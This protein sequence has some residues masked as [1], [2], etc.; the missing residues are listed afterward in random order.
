MK[1]ILCAIGLAALLLASSPARETLSVKVEPEQTKI[2]ASDGAEVII[3]I[4]LTA[5]P[6]PEK[7]LRQPLNLAVVLDRSGSMSG[8]KIEKAKQ[9]A[10]AVLDQ[11][12]SN[13]VY[14]LVAYDSQVQVLVPAQTI[15]D[16]EMLKARIFRIQPGGSTALYGG[17]ERGAEQLLKFLSSKRINR[18]IL[19]SDGLANVGPSSTEELQSLGRRLSQKGVAVTTV[20]V[21]DDYNEDLMAGLAESSDANYYYVKDAETLP[22]IFRKELGFLL[23]VTAQEVEVEINVAVGVEPLGFI[24]RSEH[25]EKRKAVVRFGP[26]SAEQN[27]YLFLRARLEDGKGKPNR[28]IAAVTV[29]YRDSSDQVQIIRHSAVVSLTKDEKAAQLSINRTIQA[30]RILMANAVAKDQAMA[31]ADAGGYEEAGN[32]FR[33]QADSLSRAATEAPAAYQQPLQAEAERLRKRAD[34]V[35]AGSWSKSSRKENQEEI[36]KEKNRKQ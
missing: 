27:R 22:D 2:L 19:L 13:D 32:K 9:A 12:G 31:T 7:K 15:E 18:V 24:G 20:G 6:A 8:A 16:K 29:R 36:Y 35:A 3:K 28:D 14:S 17:V 23:A 33:D 25:F 21:G 30:Q 10:A 4:D 26:F 11:M 5:G 34:E 1:T